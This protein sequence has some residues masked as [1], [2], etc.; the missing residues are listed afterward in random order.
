[1]ADETIGIQI[2]IGG[3]PQNIKT[4]KELTDAINKLEATAAKSD[5][6]SDEFKQAT[7]E[8]EQLKKKYNELSGDASAKV[9]T[10]INELKKRFKELKVELSN[11]ADPKEFARLSKELN[12][13]EGQIG[14][15]N[16]AANLAT[17]SGI[18][19]L[20]KGLGL[21]GEG[22]RNFDFEKIKI[23]FKGIGNAMNAAVPLLLV[24]AVTLLIEN[25]DKVKEVFFKVFPALDS[26]SESTRKLEKEQTKLIATNKIAIASIENELK[27]LEAQGV[28]EDKLLAKKNEINQTKLRELKLDNVLQSSKIRDVAANDDIL[29]SLNRLE[30]AYLKKIGQDEAAALYEKVLFNQKVE[31]AKEFADKIKENNLAIA[32]AET[33]L[34]VDKINNE[35]KKTEAVKKNLSDQDADHKAYLE[36]RKLELEAA[37]NAVQQSADINREIRKKEQEE[38]DKAL[39]EEFDKEFAALE[40]KKRLKKEAADKEI[41]LEK[42]KK[43]N[44]EKLEQDSFNAAKGLSDALF[45]I[46]LGNATKGS[47][48][49]RKLRKQQFQVEKAF[50]LARIFQDGVRAVQ[51]NLALGPLGIPL[52]IVAGVT[53]GANFA[54]VAASKFDGGSS[55]PESASVGSSAPSGNLPSPPTISTPQN[56]V[57]TFFDEQG[58][59]VQNQ[60]QR[61]VQTIDITGKVMVSE[62]DISEI[63]NR[64]GKLKTHTTF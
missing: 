40:E 15:M 18:E 61:Q 41:E 1:M 20:Q 55:S 33:A 17:G 31:R 35:N 38:K 43:D 13:V 5:F 42:K 60:T 57:S 26:V 54:K 34:T 28:S 3:V 27:I 12:D 25:F 19:Q 23:G 24:T 59:T 47:T 39:Q 53:A 49:E 2:Q 4:V 30:I 16:D 62:N 14:D 64:A 21:V 44:K 9:G 37:D 36:A 52:A 58:N 45:S 63:Q 22:F 50:T 32:A 8:A 6:G 56:N 29:E 11:A 46:Q 10:S 7:H 48:A 51:A